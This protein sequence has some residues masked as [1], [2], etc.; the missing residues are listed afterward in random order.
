MEGAYYQPL[1]RA[2]LQEN[3]DTVIRSFGFSSS[4]QTHIEKLAAKL[5]R[6]LIH[7]RYDGILFRFIDWIL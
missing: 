6:K 1:G 4:S 2:R 7:Q 3:F 5:R